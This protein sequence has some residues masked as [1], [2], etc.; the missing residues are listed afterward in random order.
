MRIR[1]LMCLVMVASVSACSTISRETAYDGAGDNAYTVVAA[2]GMRVN[3][4]QS[5]SFLFQKF[6]VDARQ[7]QPETF[8]VN[9]SGMGTIEGNEFKKPETLTT[10]LRFGGRD[11]SPGDYALI[12]RIDNAAYGYS[13]S[14]NVNCFSL[15]TAVFRIRAGHVNVLDAGNVRESRGF[16]REEIEKQAATVLAGYPLISAPL[17]FAEP[18]GTVVFEAN[19]KNFLG[20]KMCKGSGVVSFTALNTR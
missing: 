16:T 11:A 17:A 1:V 13:Q 4:S 15:G 3:G 12:A 2:D 5:Y 7:F 8:S 10:T 9:F 18:V 14:T 19:D 6:D 20:V